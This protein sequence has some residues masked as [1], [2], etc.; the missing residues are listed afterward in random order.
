VQ[1]GFLFIFDLV[2]ALLTP[3]AAVKAS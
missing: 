3:R 2:H 1:G